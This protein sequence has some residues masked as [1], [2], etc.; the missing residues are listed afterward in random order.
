MVVES[1]SSINR[2]ISTSLSV[3][4]GGFSAGVHSS[5]SSSSSPLH[6]AL[7]GGTCV[8]PKFQDKNVSNC[9]HD[10]FSS[11]KQPYN[12]FLAVQKDRSSYSGIQGTHKFNVPYVLA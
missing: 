8:P 4:G 1:C 2:K 9:D 3:L 11:T 5:L 10:I 12:K 7:A 6:F